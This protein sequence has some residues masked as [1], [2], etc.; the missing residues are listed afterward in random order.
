MEYS[1]SLRNDNH[2]L[3]A[4]GYVLYKISQSKINAFHK[5]LSAACP[6]WC[7]LPNMHCIKQKLL[8]SEYTWDIY[9]N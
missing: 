7:A 4:R 3:M 5:H 8:D 9:Q 1:V 2:M 6:E